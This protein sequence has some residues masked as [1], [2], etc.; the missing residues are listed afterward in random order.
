MNDFPAKSDIEI[1]VKLQEAETQIVRLKAVLIK[2]EKEKEKLRATLNQFEYGVEEN[3]EKLLR[4]MA[5]CR[6]TEREIQVIDDRI[7]KSNEKLRMVKTNKEYNLFLREVDDNKKRKDV[8]E[9][10]LL[11]L[12][13]ENESMEKFSLESE[14]EFQLLKDKI[15]AEQKEIEKK[16]LDDRELLDEYLANQRKIGKTITTSVMNKFVKISKMNNGSAVVGVENEV[17]L[18]GFMN[19]PPQLYIEVQRGHSLISCPQCSRILYH[20]NT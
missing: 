3:K 8:L 1:L 11:E 16:T 20:I 6:D 13:D 4:T 7:I 10:E 14:K 2:V 5:A 17:C 18:G 15:E 9:T 12:L 19:I